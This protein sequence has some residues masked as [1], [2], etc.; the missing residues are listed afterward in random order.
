MA[1][2][3]TKKMRIFAFFLTIHQER[4]VDRHDQHEDIRPTT[5]ELVF[6]QKTNKREEGARIWFYDALLE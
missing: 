4:A 1:L 3:S 2:T 6:V 5:V